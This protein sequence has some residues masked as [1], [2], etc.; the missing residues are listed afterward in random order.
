MEPAPVDIVDRGKTVVI[1]VDNDTCDAKGCPARSFVYAK[2][3]S[4][5]LSFCGSHGTQYLPEL[6]RQGAKIIDMRHTIGLTFN[7]DDE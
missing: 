4:G 3:A 7:E 6:E 5:S 1:E 2:F